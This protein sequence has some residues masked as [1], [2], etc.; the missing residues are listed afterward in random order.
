MV[1]KQRRA[2]NFGDMVKEG[3]QGI[4]EAAKDLWRKY[5]GE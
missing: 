5:Q 3:V 2:E 1:N 4:G